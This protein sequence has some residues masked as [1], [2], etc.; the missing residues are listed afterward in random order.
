M[1]HA[2]GGKVPTH[3]ERE[4]VARAERSSGPGEEG[5]WH[6]RS[7]GRLRRGVEPAEG[8]GAACGPSGPSMAT[9]PRRDEV[10]LRRRPASSSHG[11]LVHRIA[12][13]AHVFPIALRIAVLAPI[14]WRTPPVH[15]GPWELFASLLAEGLVGLGHDVTLFATGDSVT[16]GDAGHAT[17]GTR[18]VR[19]RLD[20]PQGRRVPAH[21]VGV[22]PCRGLRRHPQRLRLP[23]PDLQRPRRH[24]GGDHDP[25]VLLA[26]DRPGLRALRRHHR[27]RRD[28]RRRPP[29]APALRRHD[30]PRHRRRRLRPPSPTRRPPAVLRAHPPR[31]GHRSCHRGRPT[32]GTA[33][34]HRR[35]R[36]GRGLLP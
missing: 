24:A 18:V 32:N 8:D 29:P 5:A 20:R 31:Q 33:A 25:R 1:P 14:A 19:G 4:R 6:E 10:S 12:S 36:P 22:R 26:G 3:A 30:P 16:D 35:H 17:V 28:Q 2:V 11:T 27:L 34:R 15:Y 21:R 13:R 9:P 23:P 7:D